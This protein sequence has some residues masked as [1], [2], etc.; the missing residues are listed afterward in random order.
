MN[1]IVEEFAEKADELTFTMSGI[2]VSLAN[3]IRRTILSDINIVVFRTSPYEKNDANIIMNTSR[4]NN[5]I[6]KQRLS[7]IPIH[8]SNIEEFPIDKYYLEV[9]VQ[10]IS[11]SILYVTT[12]DFVIKDIATDKPISESKTREIFPPSNTGHFIDFVRLRPKISDEVPGEAIHL[13]CKFSIGNA[14]EDG[15]FNVVSTCSYGFTPDLNK[16]QETLGKKRADWKQEGK[17]DKEIDFESKNWE[18]LDALRITKKDSFDFI[19]QSIGIY[20]NFDLLN[21]ACDILIGQF[22]ELNILIE[23]NEI[24]IRKSQNTMANSYDIILENEDYTIGKSLEYLLFAKFYEGIKILTYC[25]YKK[26]HP[27]DS[28]SIIRLAYKENVNISFI[29]QNLLEC[30][31]DAIQ[32]FKKVKKEILKINK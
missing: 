7:C 16:I 3:A 17:T 29:K 14:K 25:G 6:I 31:S 8:I 4:L 2:N 24:I 10:N 5:E 22:N 30:V 20:S 32:I 15:M 27:H 12:E 21:K 26:M 19:I 23:T 11:N 1:P 9:K 18:L 13:T 28:D